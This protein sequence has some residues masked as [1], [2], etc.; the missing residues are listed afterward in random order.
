MVIQVLFIFGLYFYHFCSI[1]G[2]LVAP[3]GAILRE[4]YSFSEF[5]STV[6]SVLEVFFSFFLIFIVFIC[7]V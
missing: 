1:I 2:S 7:F 4:G 5:V 3:T 6:V